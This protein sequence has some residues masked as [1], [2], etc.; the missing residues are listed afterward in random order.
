MDRER[1]TRTAWSALDTAMVLLGFVLSCAVSLRLGHGHIFWEDEMLGWMMLHDPS[2]SH[3]L[4]SWKHGA[5][6]GGI[7]FYITGRAWFHVFGAS[8]TSFRLYSAACFGL[9]FALTWLAARRFYRVGPVAFALFNTWFF[10]PVLLSHM[11]EG[12]FYGLL[13]ASVAA[14]VYLFIEGAGVA[15][16]PL[17]LYALVFVAHSLLITSHLL[18]VVYSCSI[19]LGTLALDWWHGHLRPR[20]Y[21]SAAAAWLLLIPAREAIVA[22][23]QVGKP[24]FWTTQPNLPVF[25]VAYTG[26]SLRIAAVLVLLVAGVA[27]IFMLSRKRRAEMVRSAQT[28]LPVYV[29]VLMLFLVPIAFYLEGM[30]GPALFIDRYLV[31]VNIAVAFLTAELIT[32]IDFRTLFDFNRWKPAWALG[33]VAYAA[34]LGFYDFAYVGKYIIQHDGLYRGTYSQ[35]AQRCAGFV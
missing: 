4:A 22:A 12:R 7:A 19:V 13:M 14:A 5:D 10:C 8:V 31:P 30:I 24:H 26:F 20:L 16:P 21:L 6:G 25:L 11:A 9:A 33:V 29:I 34:I 3:M 18:G 35:S 27:G 1:A 23:A 15:R 17:R 32:L 2:W 28:R